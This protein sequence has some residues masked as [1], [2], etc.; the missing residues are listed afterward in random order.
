MNKKL[1][2]RIAGCLLLAIGVLSC[3]VLNGRSS[4]PAGILAE[5]PVNTSYLIDNERIK[6]ENGS[7]EWQA[8][9]GSS[10]RIKIAIAGEPVYGNLNRDNM[11]DAALFIIYQGGGSGT[12]YYIGAALSERGQYRGVNTILIGDR[13]KSPVARIQNGLITVTYFDRRPDEPMAAVPTLEQTRYFIVEE[14]S[15]QEIETADDEELF[16][17][18]LTIGHEVRSFLPCDEKESLWL[19]GNSPALQSITAAYEKTV[20]GFPPYT[21]VFSII[22]GSRT[23]APDEGYGADYQEAFLGSTLVHI[24]PTGNCRS[25][26]IIVDAPLPGAQI[27]SPLTFKGKAR[28]IWFFE[29]DFPVLLLDAHGNRIAEGYASAKGEWMTKNFVNFEGLLHFR[30]AFSGTKGSLV[31]KKDNP[32]GLPQ[33]DD[34]LEIP[35]NF[36]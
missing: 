25:D 11:E 17:G 26:L 18:W 36:E 1:S 5:S 4:V 31:L 6:L 14:S 2:C 13:I 30:D 29:G 21:P 22:S 16:Q 20:R 12:F 10:S 35:I 9:P 23:S 3:A 19:L 8:A 32:T 24:W 33:F 27:S 15:L 34:A 28:G 7:K